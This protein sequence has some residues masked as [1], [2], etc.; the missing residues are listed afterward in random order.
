MKISKPIISCLLGIFVLVTATGSV[1]ATSFPEK[2]GYLIDERGRF[3]WNGTG[4]CWRTGYWTPEMA[5]AECDPGLARKEPPKETSR[6][7][8][9]PSPSS[10]TS[11]A[12]ETES[13]SSA[14]AEKPAVEVY[15]SAATLFDFDEAEI[16]PEGRKI[17]E[18]KIVAEMKA[19]PEVELLVVTGH[20][21]FIGTEEYNQQ[22]SER[23]A[24]A[25]GVY[26][27][28][29]GVAAGRMQMVGKGES[30][31]DMQAN[32]RQAC[33]GLRG[34]RLIACLQPDRRVTV[35]SQGRVTTK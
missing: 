28:K 21:D 13:K 31:P 26:L 23:R 20:T 24:Y 5:L 25:V 2:D 34:N 16:K 10:P 3:V 27:A 19:H 1:G 22:L 33:N 8:P 30:E 18:E 32:T 35:M 15:L 14:T 11:P 29:Q 7:T 6:V 4:G 9:A 12:A 17:L